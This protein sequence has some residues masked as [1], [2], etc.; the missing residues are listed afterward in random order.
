MNK[1]NIVLVIGIITLCLFGW[2]ALTTQTVSQNNLYEE[3]IMQADEWVEKGL[4]QRAIKNYE[5]ALA[6]KTTEDLYVKIMNAYKLRYKEAPKET[7]SSYVSFLETATKYYPANKL[8]VDNLIDLYAADGKTQNIYTCLQKAIANGYDDNDIQEKFLAAKYA[9]KLKSGS[10]SAIKQ[11]SSGIYTTERRQSWNLYSLNDGYIFSSDYEFVGLC[12]SDGIVVVTGTDSRIITIKGMVLGIFDGIVTDAGIY[13]DGLLPACIDGKYGY[14]NDFAEKQFGEY[15]MASAF[16]NGSAAVK[17]NGKWHLVNTKGEVVSDTYEEIVL[18]YTGRYLVDGIIIVKISDKSYG[19][20]DE[21]WNLKATIDCSDIDMYIKGG[22]I[23]VCQNHKWGFAN[24][25]GEIVIDP[26]YDEAKSFSNGFAAVRNG[27][28]WGFI[29][30]ENKLVIEYQFTDTGY[31][32]T[33]GICPVRTD[34]PEDSTEISESWKFLE[35]VI[36]NK[37]G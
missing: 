20:Y 26:M 14:Y 33:G 18:D 15:D 35:L 8:L 31:M 22:L 25:A 10:F 27:N 24:T 19:V 17:S 34:D 2:L 23:A 6:E 28:M 4:Y 13:A 29:N 3:Y 12:G 32:E 16:Q 21:K 7:K 30:K 1:V 11:C 37:E 9:F 5:L 36:G